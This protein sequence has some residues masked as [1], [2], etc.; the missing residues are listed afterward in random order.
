MPAQHGATRGEDPFFAPLGDAFHHEYPRLI[1]AL[2]AQASPFRSAHD[3]GCIRSFLHCRGDVCSQVAR[4][5][6]NTEA[7]LVVVDWKGKLTPG[8]AR[9]LKEIFETAA[10]PVLLARE[11]PARASHLKLGKTPLRRR[12]TI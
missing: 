8:R 9:I 2:L 1:E 11:R 5:A 10:V 6:R 12:E 3:R 4:Q 7:P